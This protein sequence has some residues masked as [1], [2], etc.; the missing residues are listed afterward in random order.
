VTT[1]K[2]ATHANGLLGERPPMQLIVTV[3]GL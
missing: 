3:Y 1:V 2:E